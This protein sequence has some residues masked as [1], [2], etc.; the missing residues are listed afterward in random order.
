MESFIE[1][2][3]FLQLLHPYSS[4]NNYNF[5]KVIVNIYKIIKIISDK[6]PTAYTFLIDGDVYNNNNDNEPD[7][8]HHATDNVLNKKKYFKRLMKFINECVA[9]Y[10][11]REYTKQLIALFEYV[12]NDCVNLTI[13]QMSISEPTVNM[14]LKMTNIFNTMCN[15]RSFLNRMKNIDVKKNRSFAK[16]DTESYRKSVAELIRYAADTEDG[17]REN[18]IVKMKMTKV[19]GYCGKPNVNDYDEE[20]VHISETVFEENY[21]KNLYKLIGE[22][23]IQ[24]EIYA[25]NTTDLF[26]NY[27]IFLNIRTT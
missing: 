3:S 11:F 25:S 19:L 15:P 9:I 4:Q 13:R 24:T 5:G 2:S 26:D 20:F 14:Q 12:N 1:L 17:K 18:D 23:S 22:I 7:E 16:Y 21:F 6:S 10:E 8:H 27:S